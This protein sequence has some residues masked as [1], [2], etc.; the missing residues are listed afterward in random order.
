[1]QTKASVK[2]QIIDGYY[3]KNKKSTFNRKRRHW[4]PC[5][6]L[7]L[8]VTMERRQVGPQKKKKKRTHTEI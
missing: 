7:M 2:G 3:F 1:M 8:C 6:S 4:N 5:P